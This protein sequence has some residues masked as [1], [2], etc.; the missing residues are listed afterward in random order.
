[1]KNNLCP[2]CSGR[3]FHWIKE[4]LAKRS[5]EY[6]ATTYR[7]GEIC[8]SC[9]GTGHKPSDFWFIVWIIVASLVATAFLIQPL[10]HLW[11]D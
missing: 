9:K 7:Q 5:G 8:S 4:G 10:L 11:L 2:Q 3:G 6:L 1:V